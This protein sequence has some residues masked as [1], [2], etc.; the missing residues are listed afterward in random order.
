MTEKYYLDTCIWHDH[1]ENRI[2]KTGKILGEYA[3][4]LFKKIIDNKDKILFSKLTY[5]ELKTSYSQEEVDD[6]LN[7]L[8]LMDILEKVNISDSQLLESIKISSERNI[9]RGDVL[10]A[11][12]ARDNQVVLVTQDKHFEALKDITI[13]KKPEEI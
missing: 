1:Y 11:V 9:P 5:S 8:F 6:M 3:T 4:N 7:L 2:G 13:I 10:H 12:L